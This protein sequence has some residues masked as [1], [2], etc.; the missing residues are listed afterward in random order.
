MMLFNECELDMLA[1]V[2]ARILA[3]PDPDEEENT[4][5]GAGSAITIG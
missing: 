2:Y 5:C 4:D 1:R 3:W